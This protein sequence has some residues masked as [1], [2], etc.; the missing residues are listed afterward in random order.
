MI[1]DNIWVLPKYS[2]PQPMSNPWVPI[3]LPVL[4]ACCHWHSQK[5]F[6]FF[7]PH[8]PLAINRASGLSFPSRSMSGESS[9][10]SFKQVPVMLNCR[11][12]RLSCHQSETPRWIKMAS[13]LWFHWLSSLSKPTEPRPS[14]ISP[15]HHPII[16]GVGCWGC[17]DG[18]GEIY[19]SCKTCSL[20]KGE[21]HLHM[22][23]E[24]TIIL[25][26]GGALGEG[27]SQGPV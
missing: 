4:V 23:M 19:Q 1:H 2:P 18:S 9:S 27:F 25:M 21:G 22:P 26:Q 14:T 24:G 11:R 16:T 13:S 8:L 20:K 3:P 7:P 5:L 17:M 6:F 12:R 10:E 15:H